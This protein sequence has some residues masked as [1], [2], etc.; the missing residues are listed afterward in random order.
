MVKKCTFIHIGR[1]NSK[2]MM[3]SSVFKLHIIQFHHFQLR[4]C[5][6]KRYLASILVDCI[7]YWQW[8][9]LEAVFIIVSR[10]CQLQKVFVIIMQTNFS[11]F[12][13]RERYTL[14]LFC[15]CPAEPLYGIEHRPQSFDAS[16]IVQVNI[17]SHIID[18]LRNTNLRNEY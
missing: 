4:V 2:V 1:M 6:S 17:P 12:A 5:L 11:H 18:S 10:L 16:L 15:G 3:K 7:V 14:Y 13:N 8:H 9:Q